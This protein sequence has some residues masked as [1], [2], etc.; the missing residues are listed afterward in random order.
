MEGHILHQV[1]DA[2]I[3]K[4]PIN[5]SLGNDNESMYVSDWKNNA[6]YEF[7]LTGHLKTTIT[8]KRMNSPVGL[9][10]TNCGNDAVCD[11]NKSDYVSVILLVQENV[12]LSMCKMC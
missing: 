3:L 9:T 1:S 11:P 7:T 4:D 10:V 12:Y 2:S 8:N 6:V 5:V